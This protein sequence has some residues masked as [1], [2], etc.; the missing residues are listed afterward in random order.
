[1]SVGLPFDDLL[2][3][4][5]DAGV[6]ITVQDRGALAKLLTRYDGTSA[7]ELRD[8]VASLLARSAE[9]TEHI[10]RVFDDLYGLQ[11]LRED[12]DGDSG[13]GNPPGHAPPPP[14]PRPVPWY[15]RLRRRLAGHARW[16]IPTLVALA[17]AA[18]IYYLYSERCTGAS[19]GALA[20]LWNGC[21]GGRDGT[22]TSGTATGSADT[23]GTGG[24]GGD[25][26]LPP[27]GAELHFQ[28]AESCPAK[29]AAVIRRWPVPVLGLGLLA[30]ALAIVLFRFT[31]RR[32]TWKRVLGTRLA[33]MTGTRAY[34]LVPPPTGHVR[35]EIADIA[36]TLAAALGATARGTLDVDRTVDATA[37]AALVPTLVE[38]PRVGMGRALV[39]VD[40]ALES[41]PWRGKVEAVI[42]ALK[43][44]GVEVSTRYFA[45]HPAHVARKPTTRLE[46]IEASAATLAGDPVLIFGAG[47]GFDPRAVEARTQL[48]QALAAWPVRVLLHPAE[49]PARWP[50]GLAAGHALVAAFALTPT[51][52]RRA[53]DELI[54]LRRYQRQPHAADRTGAPELDPDDVKRLRAMLTLSPVR[55]FELAEALRAAFLP[56]APG[57]ILAEIEPVV[58]D[59]QDPAALRATDEALSALRQTPEGRRLE[60]EV[61]R[62][63]H[64]E[65]ERSRPA[66]EGSVAHLRW[67]RDLA[68]LALEM[69]VTDEERRLARREILALAATPVAAEMHD[70]LAREADGARRR[71]DA[72]TAR[73]TRRMLRDGETLSR[74]AADPTDRDDL[75]RRLAVAT[76]PVLMA[77]AAVLYLARTGA[78]TTGP[79][80]LDGTTELLSGTQD[81]QKA[82]CAFDGFYDLLV[83]PGSASGRSVSGLAVT[84]PE[85]S[86]TSASPGALVLFDLEERPPLRWFRARTLDPDFVP[87]G[88]Q[89]GAL[90]RLASGDLGLLVRHRRGEE[91]VVTLRT[92]SAST[93][94]VTQ[95]RGP[96]SAGDFGWT[97]ILPGEYVGTTYTYRGGAAELLWFDRRLQLGALPLQVSPRRAHDLA[98]AGHSGRVAPGSSQEIIARLLDPAEPLWAAPEIDCTF[99]ASELCSRACTDITADAKHCGRC[100]NACAGGMACAGGECQCPAGQTA[101]PSG[102]VDT[103]GDAE[104]CGTCGVRCPEGAACAGGVCGKVCQPPLTLCDGVCKD[105]RKDPDNCGNCGNSCRKSH[106]SYICAASRC[107]VCLAGWKTCSIADMR[108]G[109]CQT[110]TAT[111]PNNCGDCGNKCPS[112]PN[113]TRSCDEGRCGGACLPYWYDCNGSPKDGCESSAD[114]GPMGK[115]QPRAD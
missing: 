90:Q 68:M 42:A 67:R 80:R 62:F 112:R 23:G 96:E 8:A 87:A 1:M 16:L 36:T 58:D 29:D 69:A 83:E 10:R 81:V 66:A 63:L 113:M 91:V 43:E 5:T 52:A 97:P 24:A 79:V 64:R 60:Q 4:L 50:A 75:R 59:R 39:L 85:G 11:P 114:C 55:T 7:E 46:P 14:V 12:S 72:R 21:A 101:C 3:A 73:A 84:L 102:C 74:T 26:S 93:L 57:A 38:R 13:E 61:L 49:D 27:R 94:H 37:R 44:K 107:E 98:V 31:P 71:G 6:L 32:S 18:P 25:R 41:R 86:S 77:G 78:L 82:L 108:A 106:L 99:P 95:E 22:A 56:R 65:I 28:R 88:A 51:G 53:A 104:N 40:T 15:A 19:C 35:A 103:S 109:G 47:V 30:C 70:D 89:N 2:D 76:V 48:D 54:T 33:S 45:R 115:A 92:V 110:E 34:D 100:D 20:C 9:E 111:D 17:A 105:T